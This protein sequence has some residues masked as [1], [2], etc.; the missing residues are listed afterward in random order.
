MGFSSSNDMSPPSTFPLHEKVGVL[1]II[2]IEDATF[3]CTQVFLLTGGIQASFG[4]LLILLQHLVTEVKVASLIECIT[5]D[6][7]EWSQVCLF[8]LQSHFSLIAF[9]ALHFS[10]PSLSILSLFTTVRTETRWIIP[11]NGQIRRCQRGAI[12]P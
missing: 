5:Y 6:Y 8:F 1:V 2:H 11:S 10:H 7:L 3:K 4:L 12:I 9:T